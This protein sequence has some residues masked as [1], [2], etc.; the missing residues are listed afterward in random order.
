MSENITDEFSRLAGKAEEYVQTQI[1]LLNLQAAQKSSSVLSAIMAKVILFSIL[2]FAF[3][4]LSF[5]LVYVI[6][7]FTGK[8]YL[9]YFAVTGFYLLVAFI[10]HLNEYKWLRKPFM[11]AII[12][13][14]F[15]HDK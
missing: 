7:E 12:K 2:F 14:Y 8:T 1:D 3:I 9:G 13:H 5:S 15:N 10:L 4:F 11:N 6:A